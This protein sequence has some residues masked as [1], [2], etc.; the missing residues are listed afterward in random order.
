MLAAPYSEVAL[1]GLGLCL[2]I[3]GRPKCVDGKKNLLNLFQAWSLIR[4]LLK[5]ME[6]LLSSFSGEANTN[7]PPIWNT[8]GGS[9]K[10]KKLGWE[11]GRSQVMADPVSSQIEIY[12]S[13]ES[14][15]TSSLEHQLDAE[16]ETVREGQKGGW[17]L[18]N[19]P[20]SVNFRTGYGLFLPHYKLELP[21]VYF[22]S[23]G[24]HQKHFWGA[25]N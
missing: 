19:L 5:S 13:C 18:F 2:T 9:D 14:D 3:S 6:R 10:W 24:L 22:I 20:P 15:D 16:V 21:H 12:L 7:F 1:L 17:T 4:C 23:P 25:G 8:C 11:A